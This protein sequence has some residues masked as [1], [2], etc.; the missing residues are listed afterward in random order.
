MIHLAQ[1]INRITY[2]VYTVYFEAN[3]LETTDVNSP[4]EAS[5]GRPKDEEAKIW[6]KMVSEMVGN[7]LIGLN[8]HFNLRNVFADLGFQEEWSM[9]CKSSGCME[10]C[11][12]TYTVFFC[13]SP[14]AST[15]KGG[16]A[17]KMCEPPEYDRITI[18]NSHYIPSFQKKVY[19]FFQGFCPN[20]L[21]GNH[22]CFP[23]RGSWS[24]WLTASIETLVHEV[25]SPV[26][27]RDW[28]GNIFKPLEPSQFGE[29]LKFPGRCKKMCFDLFF[30]GHQYNMI[31]LCNMVW[32]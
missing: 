25:P 7:W 12:H 23:S 13:F 14:S 3:C 20:G 32:I 28:R 26:G 21:L 2:I 27:G 31:C 15:H 16:K 17:Q 22:R 1:Y 29:L 19:R 5:P 8:L 6:A 9:V 30:L 18:K 11:T 10:M 24:V 4:H